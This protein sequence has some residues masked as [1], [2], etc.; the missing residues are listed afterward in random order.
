MF[1]PYR[2]SAGA[3]LKILSPSIARPPSEVSPPLI[4]V[5]LI[6][7]LSYEGEASR[8]PN[9]EYEPKGRHLRPV[10]TFVSIRSN[11]IYDPSR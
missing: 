2:L 3:L 5:P 4:S 10:P 8:T 11:V 1:V 9:L 6:G 7:G